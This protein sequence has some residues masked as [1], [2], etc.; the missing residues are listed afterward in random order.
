MHQR[1]VF[2]DSS[3]WIA[4]RDQRQTHHS[5]ARAIVAALFKERALFISTPFVFAET[6]ATFARSGAVRERIIA[7][8]WENPLMY[9]AE[10]TDADH[11]EAITI[12]R[13]H[14][15]KSY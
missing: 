8:F 12:L 5:E 9:M 7:D 2:I 4:Y 15:D 10:V 11:R 14:Q 3:F 6:H 13:Q 1:R